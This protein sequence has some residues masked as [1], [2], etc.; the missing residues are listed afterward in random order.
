MSTYDEDDDGDALDRDIEQLESLGEEKTK[1]VLRALEDEKK[2]EDDYSDRLTR[3][4]QQ[5]NGFLDCSREEVEQQQRSL[6]IELHKK[7]EREKSDRKERNNREKNQRERILD[8]LSDVLYRKVNPKVEGK[9][10][11]HELETVVVSFTDPKSSDASINNLSFLVDANTTVQELLEGACRYWCVSPDAYILKTMGN[12]K[13]HCELQVRQCFKHG[14]LAKLKLEVKN[15]ENV[16]VTEEELKAISPKDPAKKTGSRRGQSGRN[17]ARL[18]TEGPDRAE[19]YSGNSHVQLAH[20]GGLYFL[21]KVR[22]NKPSEHFNKIKPVHIFIYLLLAFLTVFIYFSRR[23]NDDSY[24]LVRGIQDAFSITMPASEENLDFFT[25]DVLSYK[26]IRTVDEVWWWLNT[27]LPEVIWSRKSQDRDSLKDF[28]K[29]LGYVA[30]RVQNSRPVEEDQPKSQYCHRR[31]SKAVERLF[32][33]IV[34]IE[35]DKQQTSDLSRIQTYW[36]WAISGIIKDQRFRG[37]ALPYKWRSSDSNSIHGELRE[38]TSSGYTVEYRV[39]VP[40]PTEAILKYRQDLEELRRVEWISRRTRALVISCNLYNYAYDLWAS[41][42]LL[43]EQARGGT[44]RPSLHI[45]PLMTSMLETSQQLL[46]LYCEAVRILLALFILTGIGMSER[47]HKTKNRKAGVSYFWQLTGLTDVGMVICVLLPTAWR[48]ILFSKTTTAEYMTEIN[49]DAVTRGHKSLTSL[50]KTY[51]YLF[52]FDGVLMILIMYRLI[53]LLRL[54]FQVTNLWRVI[55]KALA[56]YAYLT[57]ALMPFFLALIAWI[58]AQADAFRSFRQLLMQIV[59]FNFGRADLHLFQKYPSPLGV[60]LILVTYLFFK[61]LLPNMWAAAMIDAY[62]VVSL[63]S[64]TT[65]EQWKLKDWYAWFVPAFVREILR[66]ELCMRGP[67]DG[68]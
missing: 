29:L 4:L 55:G 36:D 54:S 66:G 43:F 49:D 3:K 16:E 47:R 10:S 14:E 24:F 68:G 6:D 58:S 51:N 67:A 64:P 52:I 61:F 60:F 41:V 13:C 5:L 33:N 18:A 11:T 39:D 19:K 59:D 8:H 25:R 38:Y 30:M 9:S 44:I 31:S 62:Y 42:D 15:I 23:R 34:C 46:L 22:D 20:Y 28:N 21:L 7:E 63:T 12:S 37:P 50:G 27:T 2:R 65:G 57:L 32:G 1:A 35:K 53:S 17:E 45:Y 56:V 26:D 48:I 40:I